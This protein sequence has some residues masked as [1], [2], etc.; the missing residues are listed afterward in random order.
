MADHDRNL[1]V[2]VDV[3]M[4]PLKELR[5]RFEESLHGEAVAW[6]VDRLVSLVFPCVRRQLPRECPRV[7]DLQ[8]ATF[9][10]S[11]VDLLDMDHDV[12]TKMDRTTHLS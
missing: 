6:L 2:L 3:V 11:A 7:R 9:A 4:V 8:L 10:N 1:R 12:I 5:W